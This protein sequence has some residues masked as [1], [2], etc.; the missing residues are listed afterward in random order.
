MP[1]VQLSAH[2]VSTAT[3]KPQ[4]KK[5][6][7]YDQTIT[8]FILEVR[9][10]GG[11]TYHLRYRDAHGRQR[12]YKIGDVK[13]L[14]FDKAKQAAKVLRSKVVLG[15]SPN[16]DRNAKRAIPT[17][18]EFIRDKYLPHIETYRRN[19]ASDVSQ[20]NLHILPRFGAMHLD[21]IT[22]V[23]VDEVLQE[24]RSS[25]Y[26]MATA[27]KT[28]IMMRII[29][30]YAK[31][32]H[33]PGSEVNPA[34]G[35]KLFVPDNARERY[36]S[37]EETQRLRD[38]LDQSENPQLKFIVPLLLLT[39]ARK[40][41]ILDAKWEYVSLERR[42][43]RVPLSKSG[44]PRL[45]H[46]S[47]T[48]MS[49]LK[50]VPRFEGCPYVVPN[51]KTKVPFVSIFLSWNNARKRAGLAE[52]RMH[53][54]RHSFASNL[55]N[56]GQ[57]LYVVSKALGHSQIK[58]TSRYSHLSQETLLAAADVAAVATGVDWGVSAS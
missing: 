50:Q 17:L 25:G 9:P 20:L 56:A 52:V 36:L 10:T 12:Q 28:V 53:D 19:Y 40:R 24:M 15:E 8:G 43:L 46:L 32:L 41:E 2:F 22:Q 30:N 39:G 23:A 4:A 13:S 18:A 35:L 21:Q 7:Y 51:P 44:K 58:T 33:T 11:A 37:K 31:R 16:E 3:A 49:I 29:F 6:D 14:T 26:A 57:S 38:A 55:V 45:I 54:L 27:N 47:E 42:T 48:V 5:V 34:V 1:M